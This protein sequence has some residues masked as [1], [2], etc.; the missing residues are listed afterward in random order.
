M[1]SKI[2]FFLLSFFL[3]SCVCEDFITTYKDI[4]IE[5][6]E[7]L[8]FP[9]V[10]YESEIFDLYSDEFFLYSDEFLIDTNWPDFFEVE[11]IHPDIPP[12]IIKK[13]KSDG[14]CN[15]NNPCT[16]DFC[17]PL[18]GCINSMV[19]GIPCNDDNLCTINDYCKNGH[20]TGNPQNCDDGNVCTIDLCK[21]DTGCVHIDDSKKCDDKNPCTDDSCSPLEGCVHKL[22]PPPLCCLSNIDCEDKNPCTTDKCVKKEGFIHGYCENKPLPPPC[23]IN[24]IECDDKDPCT[25]DKCINQNCFHKPIDDPKCCKPNC[26]GKECGPDGCGGSCGKCVDGFCDGNGKCQYQCIPKCAGKEC[27]PDGCGKMCGY[28]PQGKTCNDAG[29]CIG[30]QPQ[31]AEKECGSDG[32]G[33]MCGYCPLGKNCSPDGKCVD[34][35]DLCPFETG[36]TSIGFETGNLKGWQYYGNVQIIKNL[37]ITPALEGNYMASI[38]S[39]I[40]TQESKSTMEASLC[41]PSGIEEISFMWRFYSEEFLEWCGTIYQDSFSVKVYSG[42]KSMNII[43]LTIDDLCP[44]GQC[45]N[46]GGNFIGLTKSD[47]QFDQGD[48]HVTPWHKTTHSIKPVLKPGLPITLSLSVRDGGDMIYDTV[49]LIDA[50]KFQPPSTCKKESECNDEDDCTIDLC[51]SGKCSYILKG[52]CIGPPY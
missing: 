22:V 42:D 29:K 37:G 2:I 44:P 15:D 28:C 35:C 30:C 20:C 16:K 5:E 27:G 34:A 52:E 12:D 13:C 19:E 14:E 17:D 7:T 51:E 21:L 46:C 50:I 48:V 41:L 9:D 24:D 1:K 26:L 10:K 49:V 31:C 25:E 33:G 18:K 39:G 47:I 6:K 23:C 8:P 11:V 36:C 45:G 3:P 40:Y 4:H 32:C 43:A 38:A